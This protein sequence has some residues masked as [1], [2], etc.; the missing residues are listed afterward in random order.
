MLVVTERV[1][2]VKL[3]W[4][5]VALMGEVQLGMGMAVVEVDRKGWLE[6]EVVGATR[7]AL[8]KWTVAARVAVEVRRV[9]EIVPGLRGAATGLIAPVEVSPFS[10][11]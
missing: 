11:T 10:W 1:A 3:L 4:E 5:V 6:M 9:Q 8:D 7:G 2:L